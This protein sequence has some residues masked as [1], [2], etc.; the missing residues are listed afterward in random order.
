[1]ITRVLWDVSVT[2]ALGI[3]SSYIGMEFLEK[4]FEIFKH[5]FG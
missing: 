4:V 5:Y 3:Y 2:I 1:M